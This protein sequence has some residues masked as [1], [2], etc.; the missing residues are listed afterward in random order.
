MGVTS[1]AILL[2]IILWREGEQ[3][4]EIA[5]RLLAPFTVSLVCSEVLDALEIRDDTLHLLQVVLAVV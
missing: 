3:P 2:A 4:D 1:G 5:M